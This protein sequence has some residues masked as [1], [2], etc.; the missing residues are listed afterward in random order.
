MSFTK[1]KP[2]QAPSP[3][4]PQKFQSFYL[5]LKL[6]LVSYT[7]LSDW[8]S[9][10][11]PTHAFPFPKLMGTLLRLRC[12][13]HLEPS[14]ANHSTQALSKTSVTSSRKTFPMTLASPELLEAS[15]CAT[16][17]IH[18]TPKSVVAPLGLEA[19]WE[20]DQA[21]HTLGLPHNALQR[22]SAQWYLVNKDCLSKHL[23]TQAYMIGVPDNVYTLNYS[24]WVLLNLEEVV[25]VY[26]MILM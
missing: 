12:A 23:K 14:S 11:W 20:C 9:H 17:L 21:G 7:H 2:L 15:H 26:L 10:S 24:Y 3:H 19:S 18:H 6:F 1:W 25:C 22:A 8:I 13:S 4:L 5:A 16:I